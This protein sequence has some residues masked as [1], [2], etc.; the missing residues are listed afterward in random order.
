MK[1]KLA[2]TVDMT[3]SKILRVGGKVNE[4]GQ[5]QIRVLISS[6][7]LNHELR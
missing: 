2:A 6:N 4:S 5:I 1:K 3:L 7:N